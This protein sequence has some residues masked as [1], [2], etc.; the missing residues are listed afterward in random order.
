M[1]VWPP[2]VVLWA[3][4]RL[5]TG[6]KSVSP[7]R[8]SQRRRWAGAAH[9]SRLLASASSQAIL[10][11]AVPIAGLAA[12]AWAA[13]QDGIVLTDPLVRDVGCSLVAAAGAVAWL[14]IWT[15][16]ASSGKIDSRLS[17]K[18]I[19]CG[20]APLFLVVWPLYSASPTAPLVAAT[21]PLLNALKLAAAGLRPKSDEKLVAAVSRSGS[22]TEVLSGPLIYCCVLL[23]ATL[24]GW[25]SS[26][27][28]L[29]AVSQMAVG[30]GLADIVGR[31]F[32]RTY[33]WPFAPD[34][35]L[36]GSLAFVLGATLATF[37]LSRWFA[38][39]GCFHLAL[40]PSALLLRVFLI[41]LACA[42]VELLPGLDDNISVPL[43]AAL[44]AHFFIY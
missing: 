41:S 1:G 28:A 29:V 36:A 30:D 2:L 10:E 14:K 3:C 12:V 35:S 27:A 38:L 17:R 21:V 4:C 24:F 32:G 8:A 39:F 7:I 11:K 15:S 43:V 34:K 18:I 26:P 20:S 9:G 31:R 13:T 33:K 22:A 42:F 5:G 25:R 40:D 23:A 6:L 44:L 37:A 19:H 16:L